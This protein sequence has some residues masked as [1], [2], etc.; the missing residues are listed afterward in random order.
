MPSYTNEQPVC[1]LRLPWSLKQLFFALFLYHLISYWVTA[2]I[3]ILLAKFELNWEPQDYA[4]VS[5]SYLILGTSLITLLLINWLC[6]RSELTI[7]MIW[8]EK[9]IHLHIIVPAIL[10]GIIVGMGWLSIRELNLIQEYP[11]NPMFISAIVGTCFLMPWIEELFFRGLLYEVLRTQCHL[12]NA[13]VVSAITFAVSHV[14]YWL[15]PTSLVIVFFIGII[16]A[17]LA[18]YTNSLTMPFIFHVTINLIQLM[19]FQYR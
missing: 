19:V 9:R 12:I 11:S 4:H 3:S 8:G 17:L 10:M 7:G 18:E 16:T 1:D 14:N 6:K 2:L 13:I 5:G 15:D